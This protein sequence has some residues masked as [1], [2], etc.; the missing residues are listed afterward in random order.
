MQKHSRVGL[1]A[2]LIAFAVVT[3]GLE[4]YLYFVIL[5]MARPWALYAIMVLIGLASTMKIVSLCARIAC[6]DDE[7]Q[8]EA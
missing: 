4:L 7:E 8:D 3:I 2:N 5:P 1:V 6:F